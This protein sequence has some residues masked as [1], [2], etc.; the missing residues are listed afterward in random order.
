[1]GG[2]LHVYVDFCHP[3]KKSLILSVLEPFTAGLRG[4][5]FGGRTF[6]AALVVEWG[7][8]WGT[9]MHIGQSVDR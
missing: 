9:A 6:W 8:V 7:E 3:S 2:D 5:R 4:P 1:M